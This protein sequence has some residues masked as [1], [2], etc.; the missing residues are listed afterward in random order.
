MD[1][2]KSFFNV[3]DHEGYVGKEEH[4]VNILILYYL[5]KYFIII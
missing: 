3:R 1:I 2:A 5:E 4:N